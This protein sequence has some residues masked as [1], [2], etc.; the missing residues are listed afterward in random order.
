MKQET[1]EIKQS[2]LRPLVGSDP[3]GLRDHNWS[4]R[5]PEKSEKFV[6]NEAQIYIDGCDYPDSADDLLLAIEMQQLFGAE[7]IRRMSILDAMC[8]PGRLGRELLI[9]GAQHIVFHDGDDTMT[10]HSRTQAFKIMQSGQGIGFVTSDVGSIPISDNR[11]DLIVCHNAIHQLSNIGRLRVVMEEFLRLTV[12]GG[13]IFIA[14]YQR[15]TT[16]EFLEFLE[17]RLNCTR[18]EIVPLLLPSFWASFSK[19]EFASVITSIPS[20]RRWSVIDA[21]LPMLT[22]Q[23]QETVDRDPVKGHVM[24][25]SPISLRAIV[26][27][28]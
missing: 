13:Y 27:K 3:F 9:M 24:D 4:V 6:G 16:P 15:H 28:E 23:I 1:V 25:Y 2:D 18:E 7:S 22:P 11:F 20:I 12:S 8:G 19:E 5:A 10:T 17:A 14:D 26:Q 21:Q